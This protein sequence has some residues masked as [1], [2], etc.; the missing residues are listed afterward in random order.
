MMLGTP[1]LQRDEA[2]V[3][4]ASLSLF[5]PGCWL[6]MRALVVRSQQ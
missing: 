4:V 3:T 2:F 6:A 5:R 1:S